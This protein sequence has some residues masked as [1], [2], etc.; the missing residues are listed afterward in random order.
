[1]SKIRESMPQISLYILISFLFF[2]KCGGEI[3]VTLPGCE[4]CPER[5][6]V[7]E[8]NTGKCVACLKDVHCQGISGPTKICTQD[9][10]CICG[11]DKDCPERQYCKGISGCVEC[12]TNQHCK[13]KD[14]DK[15]YCIFNLCE[16]C[17]PNEIRVCVPIGV[18]VCVKGTQT[19]RS[20]NTWGP[21]ENI[22]ICKEAE[23]CVN[24][25]CVP[26]CP[27]PIPCKKDEKQCI[28]VVYELPGRYKICQE[29]NIGCFEWGPEQTCGIRD[30]CDKGE[31]V[32]YNC[33]PPE[34][35]LNDSKCSSSEAN[36]SCP[37]GNHAQIH[38]KRWLG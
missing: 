37:F 24:E 15:P 10:R 3:N 29:N 7:G 18:T 32:P 20:S 17:K 33:P 28:T 25:K 19:C 8:S 6:L 27:E 21:C 12:L 22:V 9:Y 16:E 26:D 35:Q 31:C 5:C 4:N 30:Y 23:K 14:P 2:T 36:Q 1:M 13:D 34:C 11:S 38:H